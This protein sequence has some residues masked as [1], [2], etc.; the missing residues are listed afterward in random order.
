MKLGFYALL[1]AMVLQSAVRAVN[2]SE[3]QFATCARVCINREI[4]YPDCAFAA[5]PDYE[6][7]R[8]DLAAICPF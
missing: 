8:T 4:N 5:Q 2:I 7:C 3:S 1:L 6:I